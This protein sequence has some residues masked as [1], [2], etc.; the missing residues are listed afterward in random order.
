[1]DSTFTAAPPPAPLRLVQRFSG[2]DGFM[3]LVLP[4]NASLVNLNW[5]ENRIAAA[6]TPLL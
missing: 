6:E 4:T 3:V 5:V 2:L 1:V